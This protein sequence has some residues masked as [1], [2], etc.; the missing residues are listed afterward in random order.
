M[1]TPYLDDYIESLEQFEELTCVEFGKLQEL[2]A[3]KEA[4]EPK[5]TF[6]KFIKFLHIW[7]DYELTSIEL[8]EKLGITFKEPEIELVDGEWYFVKIEPTWDWRYLKYEKSENWTRYE[9]REKNN[10]PTE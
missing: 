9:I 7:E 1:K 5:L 8:A 6:K 2:K 4:L 10:P 3:I